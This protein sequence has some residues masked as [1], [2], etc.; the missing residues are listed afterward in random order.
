M[1][2]EFQPS[3][4]LQWCVHVGL[5]FF[6]EFVNSKRKQ[7]VD[8]AALAWQASGAAMAAEQAVRKL[9]LGAPQP[10]AAGPLTGAHQST[11]PDVR[12]PGCCHPG[13]ASA[14][15]YERWDVEPMLEHVSQ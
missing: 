3:T 14:L 11:F 8:D 12:I 4:Q 1:A 15:D 10:S 13:K 6:P 9:T 7:A 2:E 5:H